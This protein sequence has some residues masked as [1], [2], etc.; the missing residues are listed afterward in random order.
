MSDVPLHTTASSLQRHEEPSIFIAQCRKESS[1]TFPK[2]LR[3]RVQ[4]ARHE[5]RS[6]VAQ[7]RRPRGEESH[8]QPD[9]NF[10]QVLE[11]V[12]FP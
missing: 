9:V 12:D 8:Q 11:K 5:A 4:A 7:L 2:S 10:I 1:P 3:P 6:L